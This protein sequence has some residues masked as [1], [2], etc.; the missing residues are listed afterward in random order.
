ME[1]KDQLTAPEGLS[2]PFLCA[3]D[4]ILCAQALTKISMNG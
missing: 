4:N 1:D 2:A 3:P